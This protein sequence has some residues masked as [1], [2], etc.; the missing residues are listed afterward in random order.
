MKEIF[1]QYIYVISVILL[2]T[3][4][5]PDTNSLDIND[6]VAY[7]TGDISGEYRDST[8]NNNDGAPTALTFKTNCKINGCYNYTG[9]GSSSSLLIENKTNI[10]QGN[11]NYSTTMWVY[12]ND[13]S[14]DYG[15]G[16]NCFLYTRGANSAKE[17]AGLYIETDG[18]LI[19][20]YWTYDQE[21]D[22]NLL[23]NQWYFIG[24][25]Y[26]GFNTRLWINGQLNNTW[27]ND[28]LNIGNDYYYW[29]NNGGVGY[30]CDALIDE[31]SLFNV[32]LTN[33]D[34]SLLW[35]NG[36]GLTYPF[37]LENDTIFPII[38]NINQ[39]PSNISSVNALNGVYI[40]ATI[41]D[42]IELDN[43]TIYLNI[44]LI[45]ISIFVN[46]S[47]QVSTDENY[48]TATGSVYN[49]FIDDNAVYSGTYNI[50]TVI[51][52][53]TEHLNATLDNTNQWLKME[54][55][56]VSNN[57][58][59]SFYEIMSENITGDESISDYA[60][61]NSSYTIGNPINS[62]Y[63]TLFFSGSGNQPY[64]HTH[65]PRGK[66]III[67]LGIN[68]LTGYINNIKVTPISYILKRGNVHKQRY[69]YISTV[70]RET[71]MQLTGNNG[72][73]WSNLIGTVN[74]HLH[75]VG[76]NEYLNYKVCASDNSSNQ[77]CSDKIT[78]KIDFVIFPPN[79]VNIFNPIAKLYNA[80]IL[81]NHSVS[82]S[83]SG[84]DIISYKYEYA[85]NNSISFTEILENNYPDIT[86]N[87]DISDILNGGYYIKITV[88]DSLNLTSITYSE[89][90]SIINVESLNTQLLI[91]ISEKLDVSN[92]NSEEISEG[93]NMIGYVLWFITNLALFVVNVKIKDASLEIVG[94]ISGVILG[95]QLLSGYA[96]FSGLSF[97]TAWL[98][99]FRYSGEEYIR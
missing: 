24:V 7:W 48:T 90:F 59:Q 19:T 67:P 89:V 42:N 18:D 93:I 20:T 14:N 64:N 35:N 70:T 46:G 47:L 16:Y 71:A 85:E 65:T 61:C 77:K 58:Q 69:Y 5:L 82:S 26:D 51:M 83:A 98:F 80:T 15:G 33:N 13:I 1:K 72:N 68:I 37:S 94:I 62:P 2:I 34:I 88:T 21:Y 9:T 17:F 99:G 56:N 60:Y 74:A 97:L 28:D 79:A 39:N 49:F 84:H 31:H 43:S 41:T 81:I 50:N 12:F 11:T 36:N 40:N 76:N 23:I 63:C 73:T 66:H 22:T 91:D 44:S 27:N 54:F 86:Y 55:W 3:F 87:W 10:P 75:Q 30:Y 29:S 52:R 53:N 25:T 38:S 95:V 57:K 78:D 6:V 92:T 45:N 4:L 32:N 96:L 8:D